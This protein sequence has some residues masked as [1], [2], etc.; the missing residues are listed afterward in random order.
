[1]P[2]ANAIFTNTLHLVVFLNASRKQRP[3]NLAFSAS[4]LGLGTEHTNVSR[5]SLKS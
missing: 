3:S 4:N 2:E 5:D 1:M